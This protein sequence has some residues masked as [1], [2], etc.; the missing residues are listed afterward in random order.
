VLGEPVGGDVGLFE[1]AAVALVGLAVISASVGFF[2]G[3]F[4]GEL[5]GCVVGP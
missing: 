4:D 1:G 2:E 3:E 5:V